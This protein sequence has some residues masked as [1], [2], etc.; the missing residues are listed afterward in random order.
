MPADDFHYQNGAL[1]FRHITTP[2]VK[3]FSP[4]TRSSRA[5][6]NISVRVFVKN[7]HASGVALKLWPPPPI[8]INLLKNR[9]PNHP[10]LN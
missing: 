10:R 7:G 5:G 2:W 4:P 6:G 3:D 9:P 1:D 8:L